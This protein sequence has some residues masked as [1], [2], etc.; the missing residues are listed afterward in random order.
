MTFLLLTAVQFQ[1]ALW[2]AEG[3][4]SDLMRAAIESPAVASATGK[5]QYHEKELMSN[6]R[7]TV[8]QERSNTRTTKKSTCQIFEILVLICIVLMYSYVVPGTCI[9]IR[10]ITFKTAL[11]GVPRHR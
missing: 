11:Y 7:G 8:H 4:G 2:S 10:R 1:V 9:T 5:I 3:A 6:L